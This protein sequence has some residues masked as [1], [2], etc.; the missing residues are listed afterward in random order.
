MRFLRSLLF[1]ALT[2]SI[3]LADET[4][5]P[6][7]DAKPADAQ[8]ENAPVASKR[9]VPLRVVRMLP[10]THQV[11]LFDKTK[12]THVVAEVGQD[13]EGYIV[14]EIEDD[15]VTL[16]S[17]TGAEVILTAPDMTWRRRQAE[18]RAEAKKPIV[19]DPAP[20]DP[21]ADPA[22]AAA[23][24]PARMAAVTAPT[25]APIVAGSDGVRVASASGATVTPTDVA[26]PA[27]PYGGDPA[28]AAFFEAVGASSPAPTTAPTAPATK[29]APAAS[30][31]SSDGAALG[32]ALTGSPA[33]ISAPSATS[34][35]PPAAATGPTTASIK[36]TDIDAALGDFAGTAST[37]RATF[38][39][40]GL[41][42]DD[43]TAG[44][45]L[46]KV[47]LQKGDVVTNIDGQPLRSLDDAA[48]LYA[49]L[50]TAR[51]STIQVT[52]AGKPVT[53]R[54]AIQ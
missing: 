6:S 30:K 25:A 51:G 9:K 23:T 27:D 40:S 44:S 4:P 41:R 16:V 21:Y 8:P 7:S 35:A 15:E 31:S 20:V 18:R 36:R 52:R 47:G 26:A 13:I 54:I 38:T 32:A 22:E 29:A 1:V 53:L 45:L 46:S 39:P 17:P 3:A 37:F 10:E 33:P 43:V 34:S 2:G 42:F 48:N 14:D 50:P 24:E 12:G 19:A 5:P 28:V 49:R 11:L